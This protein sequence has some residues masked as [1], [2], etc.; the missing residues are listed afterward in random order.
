M[1]RGSSAAEVVLATNNAKKLAELRRIL[2]AA[3]ADE[4]GPMPPRIEILGLADVPAYPEPAETESTF[5]GNALLK[6]RACVAR[7]RPACAG[8]RL[9]TGR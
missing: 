1:E 9:R 4:T 7:H 6:A 8:R 2:A 3:A 5:E